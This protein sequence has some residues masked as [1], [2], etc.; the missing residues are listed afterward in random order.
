MSSGAMIMKNNPANSLQ[1][2]ADLVSS[3]NVISKA[4]SGAKEK[5]I[6]HSDGTSV[7]WDDFAKGLSAS[8][9]SS[10]SL[11]ITVTFS[12]FDNSICVPALNLVLDLSVEEGNSNYPIIGKN[13]SIYAYS[14]ESSKKADSLI[15][16][17]LISTLVSL[18]AGALLSFFVDYKKDIVFSATDL[19][20]ST[21]LYEI[22]AKG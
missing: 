9:K 12:N 11:I 20:E 14:Q 15:F 22:H 8:F 10:D 6:F 17:V 2:A 1:T 3:N 18:T 19:P 21:P 5:N 4:V 16:V 13:L 7:T